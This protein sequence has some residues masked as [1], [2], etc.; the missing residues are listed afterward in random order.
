MN[1]QRM[2]E[3]LKKIISEEIKILSDLQEDELEPDG[4]YNEADYIAGEMEAL[5]ARELLLKEK[6]K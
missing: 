4:Q 5:E 2:W 6:E 3:S 1:Y